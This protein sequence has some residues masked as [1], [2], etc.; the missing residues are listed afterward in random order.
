MKVLVLGGTRFFGIHLVRALLA[1][2]HEVSIAT[3]GRTSDA[4]GEQVQRII[5]ER[6]D[7]DSIARAFQG[8]RY[9][10]VFDNLAYCSNDVKYLLDNMQCRRYIMTSSASVY[11]NQHINTKENEFAPTDYPL[12]WCDRKDYPYDEVKRQAE[13]AL[14]QC[15]PYLEAVSV[16]FP[17]VIGEDDYT[18]RLYFYV[19]AVINGQPLNIDNIDEAIGFI[20]SFEAGKFIAWVA[21][22]KFAGPINGSSMGVISLRDVIDYVQQKTGREAILSE[23]GMNGPYNGQRTFSL[24]VGLADLLGYHF[25]VL[26]PWVYSLL[27][28]YIDRAIKATI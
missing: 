15:Y 28:H 16:R 13:C 25:D 12:K 11:S 7:P 18:K 3:R 19:E 17:Y 2:G 6:A 21:E 20:S 9:D 4:F 22:R 10:V 1:R 8:N 14:Y 23:K 26:K 24:D 27:D 5:I